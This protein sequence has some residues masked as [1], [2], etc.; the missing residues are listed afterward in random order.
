MADVGLGMIM[1]DASGSASFDLEA[2]I[3][4]GFIEGEAGGGFPTFDNS[5]AFT[6]QQMFIGYG[7][8]PTSKYVSATGTL[9][10][11]FS[12]HTIHGEINTLEFG[13]RGAGDFDANGQF[14]GGSSLLSITGLTFSNPLPANATEE[15]DIETNGLVH[16]FGIAHMY[17]DSADPLI[18]AR[19]TAALE[20]IYAGLQG[21]AQTYI[22]SAGVDTYTGTAFD[23]IINAGSG[24]DQLDGGAGNDTAVYN[25]NRA[26]F[27]L[28]DNGDGTWTV[29]DNRGGGFS[30]GEDTLTGIERVEFVDQTVRLT[31]IAPVAA[32]DTA[33]T[34][35]NLQKVINVL[36]NDSDADGTLDPTS[37]TIVDN[38]TN[39]TLTINTTTGAITYKP[40]AGYVGADS[41][42]YTVLDSEGK[43]S[44]IATVTLDVTSSHI[45]TAGDDVFSG[46]SLG[47]N[48]AGI[49]VHG[50]GG[51]DYIVTSNAAAH[52][53]TIYGGDGDDLIFTGRGDDFVDGGAGNDVIHARAGNETLIGGAG[54]DTFVIRFFGAS[55]DAGTTTITD[56]DGT[57]WNG[58]FRPASFPASWSPVPTAT[59]GFEITGT[60]NAAGESEWDLAVTDQAGAV[61]H[62]TITWDGEDLTLV[63]GPQTTIIKDY[64]NGT[65]G[66]TLEDVAPINLELSGTKL[67]NGVPTVFVKED[68]A[69]GTVVGTVS[70]DDIDGGALTFEVEGAAANLFEI[71][72][73]QLKLK[74][75]LDHET[76]TSHTVTVK[77]TDAGGNETTR[78]F[79]VHVR[80]V[81]DTPEGTLT[82]D[83]SAL[84]AVG[85]NF[86]S[87]LTLFFAGLTGGTPGYN[88]YGG[89]GTPNPFG[90]PNVYVTG[91]QIAFNYNE[92]G[93]PVSDKVVMGGTNFAYDFLTAGAAFGHGISGTFDSLTFGNVGSGTTL[94]QEGL[95]DDGYLTGLENAVEIS[96]FNLGAAA[97]SGSDAT[98]NNVYAAY[99]ALQQR[100]AT[101]IYDMIAKYAQNFKGTV[102]NDTY[103]GSQ[104][105]DMID[106]NGGLDV[107]VGGNGNDTYVV[108]S[109]DSIVV[110]NANHGKD[111]VKASASF[112][113]GS[114]VEDLELLGSDNLDATGNGLANK[115]TGND[116]NNTLDGQVG[117]DTMLG[118]DGDDTYIVDNAGDVAI[119]L[120]N[121]GNDT[122]RSSVN[123]VLRV[124]V[125]NLV[126]LGGAK[127]G[128]GNAGSNQLTG[129]SLANVLDG[130]AGADEMIGGL[131]NDTYVVD[132]VGDVVKELANQG[133]DTVQSSL[134]NYA[135]ATGVENLILLRSGNINGTG[136]TL[137]N[138]LTGNSGKN[139][140]DG[141][142]GADVLNGLVG[143]DT[144][145][146]G[147]G[148]DAFVFSSALVA[149]NR[150]VITDFNKLGNDT[151]RLENAVFKKL[152]KIGT[153]SKDMFVVGTKAADANDHI[154]YNKASGA[155]LYDADGSGG[156]AAVQ[157]ASLSTKP[158]ITH[159]D[160]Q[161]I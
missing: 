3:K 5:G 18:A 75:P 116:G 73:N 54:D 112:S 84:G 43:I 109:S 1:I 90:G 156:I 55:T 47:L 103:F 110:E 42:T 57:L 133:T 50:Q 66:I 101:A 74:A 37:V 113:L 6:G 19:V 135:L 150:D 60:A 91:D 129:N 139:K 13:T 72:G 32:N 4:G 71:D 83:A 38:A 130:K 105:A 79:V 7:S 36:G 104:F 63:G 120:A 31:N 40:N 51:A 22:G 92:N 93:T 122:V 11:G 123:L 10:Y 21:Y 158:T 62:L 154:I 152:T 80:D 111:L 141:G 125:E 149:N 49:E 155:L 118:G 69:A 34:V 14:V 98:L 86:S 114:N 131:G 99:A 16:L 77:V 140:L 117:A 28:T 160:F 24:N 100:N 102:G 61:Q 146:G 126:L 124:N 107:L 138:T 121:Q 52:A 108:A 46:D 96:G 23:D 29:T 147:A 26:D 35:K 48:T 161:V 70:A 94:G 132:N 159:L 144:L 78:D 65:F 134:T 148:N 89:S 20:K 142:A 8:D 56:T 44:N 145:T 106:G 85:V 30:D 136:N 153:L 143:N 64:V 53:D 76:E 97:G 45:L 15:A 9:S 157:F 68:A 2:F 27:T 82:I 12:S 81:L 39:G 25:G 87:Y 88:F 137:A 128:T 115:L 151:I 41:F 58:T 119:E 17:G 127:T 59:S 67:L 95:L 33:S